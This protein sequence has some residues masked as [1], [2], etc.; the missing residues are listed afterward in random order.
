M[1]LDINSVSKKFDKQIVLD[2][3]SLQIPEGSILGLL[4]RNGI[5]KSTLINSMID[6]LPLDSGTISYDGKSLIEDELE[7][8]RNLGIVGEQNQLV[9]EFSGIN[10][11]NFVGE[12]YKVPSSELKSRIESLV[13]FFFTDKD[14]L[15][16][17]ISSYSTGMKKLIGVCAAVLHTPKYLLM[18]E[19]FSGLDAVA[20]Q[21]LVQFIKNYQNGD[22]VI[23]ISSHILYHLEKVATDIAVLNEGKIVYH[24]SLDAFTSE[25]KAELDKAL[26]DL[27]VVEDVQ[28]DD[29]SWIQ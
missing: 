8:K 11:L 5:G 18:D 4:G 3:I 19:P 1:A 2:N 16:K 13:S 17:R 29:L 15:K 27:L 6:L 21:K 12:L 7:V 24:N 14:V 20:T 28:M 25:G 9:E 10:Y 22:R 23:L 26:L